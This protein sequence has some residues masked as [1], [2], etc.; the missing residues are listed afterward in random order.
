MRKVVA[1]AL[2]DLRLL[3]RDKA[4]FIFTFFF[5]LVYC[6]FFG[7]IFSGQAGGSTNAMKIAV[8]DED[9]T[10]GSRA[11]IQTLHDAAEV[12]VELTDRATAE[13]A[14]RLGKRVAYVVLP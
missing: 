5:P 6:L 12:E 13:A 8:V 4:G 10:G 3:V 2:K 14:V 7:A 1:L 11:F 9:G